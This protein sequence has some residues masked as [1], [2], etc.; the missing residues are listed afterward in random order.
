MDRVPKPYFVPFKDVLLLLVPEGPTLEHEAPDDSVLL[1]L[2]RGLWGGELSLL[3]SWEQQSL[4]ELGQGVWVEV[5]EP[6]RNE[7]EGPLLLLQADV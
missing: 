4:S 5:L 3:Y 2:F 6:P 1:P 7:K